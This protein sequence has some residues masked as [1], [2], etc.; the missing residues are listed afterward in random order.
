NLLADGTQVKTAEVKADADGNWKYS[1][2]GLPKFKDGVEIKYTV[3]EETVAGYTTEINGFDITNKY[4]P[5]MIGIAGTKTWDD[6]NNQDGKRPEKITVNLLADG[7]QVKTAEVKADA[8]GNWK[9]SFSGLPKFKAGK[10]I[11]YTVTENTVEG[12]TTEI[13]GFNIKNSY[14]PGMT[15]V[16]VT[17]RWDDSDNKDKIRPTSIK[18]QLYADGKKVG[19]EVVL[20]AADQW[21]YT[22]KELPAMKDGKTI[23]Y[24]VKEV[25]KVDGYTVSVN[26]RNHG[27]IIITN[28]HKPNRPPVPSTGD[29]TQ[30]TVFAAGL[31][32]AMA[33]IAGAIVARK[34]IG[35]R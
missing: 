5:E 12:Y 22:W 19:G 28:S 31:A 25:S 34:K 6:A 21:T 30:L 14:K 18:V 33:A 10:E 2:S 13:N 9:Y 29:G 16:T 3:T 4:T 32:L 35:E 15:S 26:D 27:N 11:K 8:D 1:F 23:K 7:T 24:T 17:K 20:K